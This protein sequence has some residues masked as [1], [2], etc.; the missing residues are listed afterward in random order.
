MAANDM[1]ATWDAFCDTLKVAGQELIKD[2]VPRDEQSQAEG[3]RYLSRMARAALEWYVEF[4]DAAFPVLYQPAHETIKLG[5][6]NPDNIY[7]K[8]V[9]DGRFEYRLTGKRGSID[10]ISFATS[11]GSYA[12]NFKQIE[13]GFL[14]SNT[15]EID[16]EG[17]FEIILS[18]NEQSGNWLSMDT[19]SESLLIRQT[20]LDRSLETSADIQIHRVDTTAVPSPLSKEKVTADFEKAMAF[21]RNTVGLFSQWSKEIRENPNS[22]PLWD[23]AFCQAVGGDPNIIYYHGHFRLNSDEVMIVTLPSVPECQT[24][25]LQVDNYWMESLDYRYHKISINR[26]TASV[27]A[28]GS[29]D[30]HI[31]VKNN[32]HANWLSTGGHVEGTLC[33]RWVGC[34]DPVNPTTRVIHASDASA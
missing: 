25:N 10:Y 22:L 12:E 3:L 31:A 2:H 23:Q 9:I 8:A 6:D 28:D 33:F 32:G 19:E 16:A 20:F 7:Q 27:K 5:A 29:V 11:K 24:W 34:K 21:Y 26:H 15:I 30:I 14:D 18:A 17:N 4:N 1:A 13:T